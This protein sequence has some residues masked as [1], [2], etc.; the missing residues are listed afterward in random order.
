MS[1]VPRK[2]NRCYF[3]AAP[4][5]IIS[6]PSFTGGA[7]PAAPT[8]AMAFAWEPRARSNVNRYPGRCG[9]WPVA[10]RWL[11]RRLLGISPGFCGP[12]IQVLRRSNG[13]DDARGDHGLAEIP[14]FRRVRKNEKIL[15]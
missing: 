15:T 6:G 5:T 14:R 11:R 7:T 10:W 12:K 8:L 9:S 4:A 2:T 13:P 1:S 3:F